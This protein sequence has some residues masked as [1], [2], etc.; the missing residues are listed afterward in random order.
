MPVELDGVCN[1]QPL[2]LPGVAE[3]QPVV[4]LLMLEPIMDCLQH[5]TLPF[6]AWLRIVL[7]H[8]VHGCAWLLKGQARVKA[9]LTRCSVQLLRLKHM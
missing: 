8:S 5:Y 3:I 4:R 7:C 6:C 2:N 1:V 9:K